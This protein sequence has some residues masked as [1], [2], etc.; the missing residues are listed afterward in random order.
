MVFGA[1]P[2]S[3]HFDHLI[4]KQLTPKKGKILGVKKAH[5]SAS[6]NDPQRWEDLL[7]KENPLYITVMSKGSHPKQNNAWELRLIHS[8]VM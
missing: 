5:W 4:D 1:V 3:L 7:K 8:I 2:A 6:T